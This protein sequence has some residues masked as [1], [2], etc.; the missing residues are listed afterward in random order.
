M[1]YFESLNGLVYLEL[2]KDFLMKAEV[3]TKQDYDMFIQAKIAKH[4]SLKDKT[5]EEM[6]L[7]PFLGTKIRSFMAGMNI[8]IRSEHIWD[9]MKLSTNGRIL[10]AMKLSRTL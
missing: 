9:T 7:R 3:F 4:H 1:F 8:S 10:K 5:P 2:V 6:G